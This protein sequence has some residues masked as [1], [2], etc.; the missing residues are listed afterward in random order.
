[1]DALTDFVARLND[2]APA[3]QTLE[4]FDATSVSEALKWTDLLQDVVYQ[5]ISARIVN[6]HLGQ[7]YLFSIFR[8]SWYLIILLISNKFILC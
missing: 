6:T 7:H 5:G 4:D 1:M 3:F 2:P 8:C